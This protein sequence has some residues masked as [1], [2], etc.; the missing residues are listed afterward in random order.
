MFCIFL[1]IRILTYVFSPIDGVN[2]EL[3]NYVRKWELLNSEIMKHEE[4]IE[5]QRRQLSMLN[6][7]LNDRELGT[8]K[9]QRKR[10]SA[11]DLIAQE[12]EEI[13]QL[14]AELSQRSKE[15]I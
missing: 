14:E 4:T 9:T 10:K 1:E 8:E 11:K 5:K 6:I 12:E 2:E 15:Q 3:E 13:R 7:S